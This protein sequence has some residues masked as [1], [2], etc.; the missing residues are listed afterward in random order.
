M[1]PRQQLLLAW[2]ASAALTAGAVSAWWRA[3]PSIDQ[4]VRGPAPGLAGGA[5]PF[6]SSQVADAARRTRDDDP[7]R[8]ARRPS[9]V[10]Y[11][12]DW[13]AAA[14]PSSVPNGPPKPTLV[15]VGLIGG[16]PWNALIEGLP[17]REQ[18]VMLGLGEEVAGIRLRRIAG[19]N[20]ILSGLDTTW[21]LTPRRTW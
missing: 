7:F 6:D 11:R 9:A 5:A 14:E 13:Q 21:V 15:L 3:V 4:P 8:I 17:G 16:P 18:G 10:A 19:D 20:V 12:P 2:L 1:N